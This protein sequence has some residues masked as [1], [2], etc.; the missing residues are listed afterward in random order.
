MIGIGANLTLLFAPRCDP[1]TLFF[2]EVVLMSFAEH[3]RIQ[4]TTNCLKLEKILSIEKNSPTSSL[5][6]SYRTACGLLVTST[7]VALL[8]VY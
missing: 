6:S 8:A 7:C 2:V 4:V 5:R 3:R 1:F